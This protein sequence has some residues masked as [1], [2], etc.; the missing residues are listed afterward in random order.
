VDEVIDVSNN[1]NVTFWNLLLLPD[2]T[3]ENSLNSPLMLV[4]TLNNLQ[5]EIQQFIPR[6]E[7]GPFITMQN[8]PLNIPAFEIPPALVTT[9]TNT[10]SFQF[11]LT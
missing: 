4:Q 7:S 8:L 9:Q 10:I 1:P 3:N 5:A 2:P 11:S 6:L